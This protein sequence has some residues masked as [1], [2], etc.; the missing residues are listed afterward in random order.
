[1]KQSVMT[2]PGVIEIRDVPVPAPGPN[3]VLLRMKRIGV[4]GSDI[5]VWHGLPGQV[6]LFR[7]QYPFRVHAEFEAGALKESNYGIEPEMA[8]KPQL[9]VVRELADGYQYPKGR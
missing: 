5:H 6:I 8:E 1:M 4:C 2:S 7:P 3:E 9:G